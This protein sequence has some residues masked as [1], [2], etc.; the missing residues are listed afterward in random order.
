MEEKE[1][2][3][4]SWTNLFIVT[5]L[6]FLGFSWLLKLLDESHIQLFFRIGLLSTALGVIAYLNAWL[7]PKFYNKGETSLSSSQ[8]QEQHL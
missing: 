8:Q 2:S 7:S 4:F 6:S 1:L 3:E 5:G